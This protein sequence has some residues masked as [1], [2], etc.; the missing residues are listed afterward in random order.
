MV[1]VSKKGYHLKKEQG[2][3]LLELLIV[4]FLITLTT[5][6][7][8]IFLANAMQSKNIDS[9]ARELSVFIR[10]VNSLAR[11][12]GQTKALIIDL[13]RGYY[14]IEKE[15]FKKI[16]DKIKIK[17][18]D[19]TVGELERGKYSIIFEPFGSIPAA[20]IVLYN[21]SHSIKLEI[22]PIVGAVLVK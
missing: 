16:P 22:D 7:G 17:I 5:G 3:T 10:H 14:G 1:I 21:N 4:I 12:D 18:V 6:I 11:V 13:D 20:T 9:I 19:P 15:G 2:F 8:S